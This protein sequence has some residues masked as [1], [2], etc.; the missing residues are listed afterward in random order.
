MSEQKT[1]CIACTTRTLERNKRRVKV[2][3]T[4]ITC[5]WS[6]SCRKLKKRS[7]YKDRQRK[8][9][10]CWSVSQTNANWRFVLICILT[11][12]KY[13]R[14]VSVDVLLFVPGLMSNIVATHKESLSKSLGNIPFSGEFCSITN[15]QRLNRVIQRMYYWNLI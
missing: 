12:W 4:A 8:N 7:K 9:T 3:R 5:Y 13:D 15:N 6:N 2:S 14:A 11:I 1:T 10:Y